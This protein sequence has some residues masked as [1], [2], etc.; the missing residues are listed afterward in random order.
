MNSIIKLNNVQ[1][2]N[3]L[4][5]AETLHPLV[6]VTDLS[7]LESIRHC[8]KNFGFYCVFFKELDCGTVLYGRSKY[9]YQEGTMLFIAPGQIA[10]VDD[11]GETL[12][13]KG[14][15]LMFHPDLLYGTPLMRRMKDY[16]FFSYTCDEALHMSEREKTII[17]NC[18]RE[19]REELEHAI[20]KHTKQIVASN[21]ETMLN[22]CVRFYER[23]FVT[24]EVSNRSVL[25]RF[26]EILHDYLNSD[27]PKLEGL[28]TV[29]YCADKICLSPN[30]FGDLIKKE[31]GK[32]AQEYIQLAV[33]GRIKELLTET[34]K[35]ISEIAYDLGFN[36]PHHLSRIFKKVVGITPNEYR[37]KA[38]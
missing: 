21:I 6:S 22:H 12:N 28:P 16:S 14:W 4:L 13:P 38:S 30:Y 31:T 26:E 10:G 25:D 9:D 19:I 20:D 2:Y 32:T 18:F 36:Y 29:Q 8:R 24:R 15:V 7:T 27:K 33:I 3:R 5:G 11:G 37:L 23:Q 1:D 17:I 35:T 34:D